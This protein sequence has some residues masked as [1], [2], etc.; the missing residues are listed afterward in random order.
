MQGTL[1]RNREPAIDPQVSQESIGFGSS[2]WSAVLCIWDIRYVTR[3]KKEPSL[4]RFTGFEQTSLSVYSHDMH[5]LLDGEDRGCPQINA[6]DLDC[7]GSFSSE[8]STYSDV[9]LFSAKCSISYTPCRIYPCQLAHINSW[10]WPALFRSSTDWSS[11]STVSEVQPTLSWM[12]NS[13]LLC[14][15]R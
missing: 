15:R 12:L 4:D 9:C 5:S 13:I 1:I 7:H 6:H 3:G 2:T 11:I 10:N 14:L 8:Q